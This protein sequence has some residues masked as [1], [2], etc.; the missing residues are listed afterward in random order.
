MKLTLLTQTTE[1]YWSLMALTAPN[2]LEYCLR[3]KVAFQ[4][5]KLMTFTYENWAE[6]NVSMLNTLR[7]TDWLMFMGADTLIM[8][9]TINVHDMLKQYQEHEFVIAEDINGINNDVF[10]LQNTNN[11]IK[12]LETIIDEYGT[13]KNDQDAM[14]KHLSMVSHIIEP[15]RKFNSYLYSQYNYPDD[16]GGSYQPGD[17]ILHLPGLNNLKRSTI[18]QQYLP[19][20]IK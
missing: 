13:S 7:N 17:F 1:Q 20:V 12:F 15:Q 18:I 14:K 2:K 9:H 11:S 10:F 16:K 19:S 4:C 8:N 3:H 5:D 6:R